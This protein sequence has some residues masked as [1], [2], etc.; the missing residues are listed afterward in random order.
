M[1]SLPGNHP[2]RQQA[3]SIV[4]AA[5]APEYPNATLIDTVGTLYATPGERVIFIS[6]IVQ[7]TGAAGFTLQPG[8]IPTGETNTLSDVSASIAANAVASEPQSDT[9]YCSRDDQH[10][11]SRGDKF[12]PK[13]GA[14]VVKKPVTS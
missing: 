3:N 5:C 4:L 1:E 11:A 10:V 6:R 14:P 2:D 13:C 9:Y 8:V 7:Y 12:C